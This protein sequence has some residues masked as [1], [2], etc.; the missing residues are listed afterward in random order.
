MAPESQQ[1]GIENPH[2]LSKRSTELVWEGKYDELGNRREIELP[3]KPIPLVKIE[4]SEQFKSRSWRN[5]LICGENKL[6]MHSLMPKFRGKID[7]IYIDP[8]FSL[9]GDFMMNVAAGDSQEQD[10]QKFETLAYRDSWG[11]NKGV[12]LQMIFER[13]TLM[14]EL[15]S[16][17]GSIYVHCDESVSFLVRSIMNEIFGEE[18]FVREIIW[19]IG[20][21]SGFKSRV[22]NWIRNHDSILFYKKGDKYTF[23]KEYIPY[24][25]D[26]VRRD[27]KPSKAHGYPIEDTWNCSELDRLDS[28]Q[29]MSF[30]GEK[31]G[32]I[33][34]KNEK[35]IE[36]IIRASSNEGDLVADFFSGSGTTGTVAEK[37]GRKWIMCDI[38][39]MAIAIT[40]KRL[41]GNRI[42]SKYTPF[43]IYEL[44]GSAHNNWRLKL[45]RDTHDEY[46]ER[47]SRIYLKQSKQKPTVYVAEI[48]SPLSSSDLKKILKT[49]GLDL[50]TGEL[51]LLARNFENSVRKTADGFEKKLGIII[52]LKTIP[53]E[54]T[55]QIFGSS[56]HFSELSKMNAKAVFY[57]HNNQRA[58]DVRLIDFSPSFSAFLSSE[59]IA[60]RGLDFLDFWAVDFEYI[61]DAAF[62]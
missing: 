35:L 41:L 36:R 34:Q 16:E 37:L 48:D 54:I 29:I 26:Y 46:R 9:K 25:E 20:W 51:H 7:L 62:K 56:V 58:Y 6:V 13:L 39:N 21:I 17:T 52:R 43:D 59:K 24:P 14:R 55:D 45:L 42:N 12:F 27:G 50:S 30:S 47:I 44:D 38:G 15:L 10:A 23:N 2:P 22:K 31:T 40:R 57:E 1:W 19:R 4:S 53:N 11:Q 18:N 3:E 32:Y 28:I 8:P 60:F 5:I 61:P 33:T 49:P